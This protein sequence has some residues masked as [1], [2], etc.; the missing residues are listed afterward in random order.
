[1]NTDTLGIGCVSAIGTD[2]EMDRTLFCEA[3]VGCDAFTGNVDEQTESINQSIYFEKM[4]IT[5]NELTACQNDVE[6]VAM[7]VGLSCN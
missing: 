6:S 2:M 3:E 5:Q 7:T 1:M 4:T